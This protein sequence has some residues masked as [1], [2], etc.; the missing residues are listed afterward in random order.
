[1]RLQRGRERFI[2]AVT[3]ST[4]G[5]AS[6]VA[7]VNSPEVNSR[8]ETELLSFC[9]VITESNIFFQSNIIILSLVFHV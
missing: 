5:H 9:V 3:S 7:K 2:K 4:D 6:R 1:M 8:F